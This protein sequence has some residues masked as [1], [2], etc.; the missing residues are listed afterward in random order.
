M[1]RSIKKGPYIE[2]SLIKKLSI[3][4]YDRVILYINPKKQRIGFKFYLNK[5]YQ[6]RRKFGLYSDKTLEAIKHNLQLFHANKQ[7]ISFGYLIYN[8]NQIFNNFCFEKQYV[9]QISHILKQHAWIKQN[10][11]Y[12]LQFD[13]IH[14][15]WEVQ[16]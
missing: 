12:Q 10:T 1:P 11:H 4:G 13:Y 2:E 5:S 16:L 15:R 14:N 8:N 3:K 7:D 6:H 9:I